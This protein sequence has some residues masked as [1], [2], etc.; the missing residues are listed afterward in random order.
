LTDDPVTVCHLFQINALLINAPWF[1]V[2]ILTLYPHQL[3]A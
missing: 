3:T 1:I 2:N